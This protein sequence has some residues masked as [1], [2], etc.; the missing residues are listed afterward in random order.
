MT[1]MTWDGKWLSSD[2]RRTTYVRNRKTNVRRK[3][4]HK[5]NY[6][7]I[8]MYAVREKGWQKKE[9]LYFNG[10]KVV[11]TARCGSVLTT[12][13]MTDVLEA[14][15]DLI[16]TFQLRHK[17]GKLVK[18]RIGSLFIVTET[19]AWLFRY[20][21]TRGIVVKEIG[22][23]K[24]AMGT[25]ARTA[26]FLMRHLGLD[27]MHAAAAV[28][29]MTKKCGGDIKTVRRDETDPELAAEVYNTSTREKET[30]RSQIGHAIALL[31]IDSPIPEDP[32]A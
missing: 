8:T 24:F 18:C 2:S 32:T 26:S 11:A 15:K 29:L 25:D 5:S 7:K 6:D 13:A 31:V 27:A 1:I 14:G 28:T 20:S 10:Q 3:K 19:S 4:G 23:S 21:P 30:L 22:E 9:R 17:R 12:T 16:R